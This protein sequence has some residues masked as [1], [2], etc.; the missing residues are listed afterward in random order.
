MRK[1]DKQ[2]LTPYQKLEQES[3]LSA[4]SEEPKPGSR[5][6]G[7]RVLSDVNAPAR[8]RKAGLTEAALPGTGPTDDDLSPETL[9]HEDGA[10]SPFDPGEGAPADET[11]R[12]V[13]EGEIGAGHGLDEAELGRVAPLD[14]KPWNPEEASEAER[15][16]P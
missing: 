13:S 8:V 16:Q 12:M 4:D 5:R 10:R 3:R 9:I 14:G 1:S 2:K 7:D 11:Y 6:A 15:S